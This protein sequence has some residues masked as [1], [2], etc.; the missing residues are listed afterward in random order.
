MTYKLQKNK[1]FAL[2]LFMLLNSI[3]LSKQTKK[4][5]TSALSENKTKN[6]KYE[7]KLF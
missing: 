1:I 4:I 7:S 5:S 3:V 6:N 2:T